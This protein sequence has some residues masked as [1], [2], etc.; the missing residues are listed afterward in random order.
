MNGQKHWFK[1]GTMDEIEHEYQ[2]MIQFKA[3]NSKY[4]VKTK[5]NMIL[6]TKKQETQ[7]TKNMIMIM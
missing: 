5:I 7:N 1:T 3:K 6:L 4:S 2:T